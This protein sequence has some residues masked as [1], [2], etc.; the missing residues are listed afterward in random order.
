MAGASG[1]ADV[2]DVPATVAG[3]GYAAAP[4]RPAVAT[5]SAAVMANTLPAAVKEVRFRMF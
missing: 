4:A 1:A 5:E 3:T 2:A